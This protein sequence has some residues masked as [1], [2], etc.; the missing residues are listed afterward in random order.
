MK[1]RRPLALVMAIL[2][3]LSMLAGCGANTK[4][5]YEAWL[6]KTTEEMNALAQK[7]ADVMAAQD[8]AVATTYYDEAITSFDKWIKEAGEIKVPS[9]MQQ[10]HQTLVDALTT[11]KSTLDQLKNLIPAQ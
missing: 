8:P 1:L 7:G 3:C 11:Q 2:I 5:D 10:D 4:K 9:D 6:T